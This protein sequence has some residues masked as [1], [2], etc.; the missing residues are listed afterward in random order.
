MMRAADASEPSDGSDRKHPLDVCQ[1]VSNQSTL[2]K[3]PPLQSITSFCYKLLKLLRLVKSVT[4]HP[5]AS[6]W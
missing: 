5:S 4:F 6:G 3:N 1:I 2:K